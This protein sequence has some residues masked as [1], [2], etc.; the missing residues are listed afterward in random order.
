MDYCTLANARSIPVAQ[1]LTERLDALGRVEDIGELKIK[2]SGCI[3]ACGQH[4]IGHIGI[5][6]VDK[7]GD[8]FYQV[9]IG[10]EAEGGSALG[11]IVGPAVPGDRIVDAV[12]ALVATYLHRR[13]DGERFIDTF[14]RIGLEPFKESLH[15]IDQERPH[16]RR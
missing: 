1:R 6:G 8:E 12:E 14:H 3:N 7:R 13:S 2:I 5:C 16:H 9:T 15:A 11:R 10:G 4:S